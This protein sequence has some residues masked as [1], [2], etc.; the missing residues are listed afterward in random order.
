MTDELSTP[1]PED[2]VKGA[3]EWHED[4]KLCFEWLRNLERGRFSERRCRLIRLTV[5]QDELDHFNRI[6]AGELI[7]LD[8]SLSR[9]LPQKRGF[10]RMVSASFGP[11]RGR[12]RFEDGYRDGGLRK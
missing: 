4:G 3:S 12:A 10:L 2:H 5:V 8:V 9:T 1:C 11:V 7:R 6:D